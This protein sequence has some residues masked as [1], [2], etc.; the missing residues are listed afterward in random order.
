MP[1][2]RGILA[3]SADPGIFCS[4]FE[5]RFLPS[6]GL[7]IGSLSGSFA[8]CYLRNSPV[9]TTRRKPALAN[10]P[11]LPSV[12]QAQLGR[13]GDQRHT[14]QSVPHPLLQAILSRLRGQWR[15]SGT[16]FSAICRLKYLV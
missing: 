16:A 4:N 12:E 10:M 15:S 9:R 11:P 3:S 14:G 8:I 2:C 7:A 5:E 6:V 1:E 13:D